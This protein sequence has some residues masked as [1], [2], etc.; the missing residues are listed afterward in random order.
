MI[1][2]EQSSHVSDLI[3]VVIPVHDP[4]LL[5][6]DVLYVTVVGSVSAIVTFVAWDGPLFVA[7]K[8]YVTTEAAK[9]K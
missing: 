7:V 4:P 6:E 2:A 9:I 3:S 8:T 5:N 1:D